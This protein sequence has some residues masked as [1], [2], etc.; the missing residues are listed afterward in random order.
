MNNSCYILHIDISNKI[1][2][3]KK[4]KIKDNIYILLNDNPILTKISNISFIVKWKV[5][6][7]TNL[8]NYYTEI[9]DIICEKAIQHHVKLLYH[10]I[11]RI[12]NIDESCIKCILDKKCLNIKSML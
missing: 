1:C 8:L 9:S 4:A 10:N 5:N 7:K 2:E 6:D 12:V 11:S 3:I